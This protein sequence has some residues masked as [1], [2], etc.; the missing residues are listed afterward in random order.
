MQFIPGCE[1]IPF[2]VLTELLGL[3]DLGL[4]MIP[5]LG[6]G[7]DLGF[8]LLGQVGK[9]SSQFG[10]GVLLFLQLGSM[11]FLKFFLLSWRKWTSQ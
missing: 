1:E 7:L 2:L 6:E 9:L 3:L 10:G 4:M 8:M 11:P 5:V